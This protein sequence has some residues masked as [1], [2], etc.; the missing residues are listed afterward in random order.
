MVSNTKRQREKI[1]AQFITRS[2]VV[3]KAERS[4]A[5]RRSENSKSA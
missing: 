1:Q 5:A 4:K 2:K 3:V